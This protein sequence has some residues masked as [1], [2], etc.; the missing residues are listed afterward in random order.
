[1]LDVR[2]L[3]V[4]NE[5][6]K[7]GSFSAAAAALGY[8]QPAISRQ[9][10]LLERETGAILLERGP[11]SV[12]L[13]DAGALLVDHAQAILSRL[14]DAE[15]D[16]REL[17]GLEAGR[18]KMSTLT[19]AAA[20][21]VPLAVTE[22]RRRLP[23]V[24]LSV[25][26][27]EPP[28]VLPALRRGDVDLALCNDAGHLE[29]PDIEAVR[30]FDEPMLIA[31]PQGHPL[32]RRKRLHL[33]ELADEAWMLATT[34]NCPDAGRFMRA[35]HSAGFDPQIAFQH[36]DY[37]AV[38]GFVAA[39]VG[40]APVPEMIARTRRPGVHIVSLGGETITRTI[41][42]SMPRGYRPR[43]AQAML[44][45]LNEVAEEW[46]AGTDRHRLQVV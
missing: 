12:R 23:G 8:T 11:G 16:L 36:D 38:L 32:G 9:V 27:L 40:A 28:A 42:V 3:R 10:A 4:L 34:E 1:M 33:S 37:G 29:L 7:R 24:E 13:T 31:L 15:H 6:A 19:S 18:L 44:E 26:M 46:R 43:A 20:T 41:V 2:R 17:M 30:L 14:E 39:G 21:I 22:F 45:V 25:S 35:C 5:V